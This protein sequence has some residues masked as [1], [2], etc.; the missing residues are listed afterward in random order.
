[1]ACRSYISPLVVRARC[2]VA[3]RA[4]GGVAWWSTGTF[5]GLPYMAHKAARWPASQA[6]ACLWS[7][8]RNYA[9]AVRKWPRPLRRRI[10]QGGLTEWGS[11]SY[12]VDC[13]EIRV[14][15]MEGGRLAV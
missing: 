10:L 15:A 1:M 9:A 12:W 6:C 5:W 3:I 14:N 8:P 2:P 7:W 4:T 13:F 11:N